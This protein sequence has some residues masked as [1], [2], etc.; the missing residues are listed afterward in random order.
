MFLWEINIQA[1]TYVLKPNF[2][3]R[4]KYA[5][6]SPLGFLN[7]ILITGCMDSFR[8][9]KKRCKRGVY[10]HMTF[11]YI[12]STDLSMLDLVSAILFKLETLKP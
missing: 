5:E 2:L 9:T 11:M 7:H 6:G 3:R 1:S 10:A 8:Q 4:L 12:Y